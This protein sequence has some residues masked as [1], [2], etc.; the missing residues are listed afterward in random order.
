VISDF[1]FFSDTKGWLKGFLAE[2]F[3]E[4]FTGECYKGFY[5]DSFGKK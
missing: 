4:D 1:N 2:G 5:I 3:T